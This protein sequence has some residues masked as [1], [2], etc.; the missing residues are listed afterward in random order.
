M[1]NE[2]AE[3]WGGRIS[4]RHCNWICLQGWSECTRNLK[5]IRLLIHIWTPGC[6]VGVI[7]LHSRFYNCEYFRCNIN[8]SVTVSER[9]KACTAFLRSEVGIV[10]SNPT[11]GMDV[12]CVCSFFCVC[13]VLCLGR[14]LS[15]SWSPVQGVLPSVNDQET[16]KSAL[17]SKKWSRLPNGSKE[18]EKH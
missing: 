14:G 5:I 10:G 7:L 15:T 3:V 6:Q 4:W 8:E 13:V 16:E 9:S 17:C 12:W 18:E 2:F 11:H 1:S